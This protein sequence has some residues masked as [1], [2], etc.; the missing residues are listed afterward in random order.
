MQ[1]INQT[2]TA[3]V[4]PL[5]HWSLWC[6]D[7]VG[8]LDRLRITPKRKIPV[9]YTPSVYTSDNGWLWEC[10]HVDVTTETVDFV[11]EY[12]EAITGELQPITY[13]II[14]SCNNCHA[15]KSVWHDEWTEVEWND[16]GML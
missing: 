3:K 13:D 14:E 12:R 11:D 1:T 8:S 4:T 16:N 10:E 7:V 9:D 6:N 15:Y 5:G 2:L